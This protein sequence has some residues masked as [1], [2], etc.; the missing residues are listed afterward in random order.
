MTLVE[1]KAAPSKMTSLTS[2]HP[3]LGKTNKQTNQ[4]NKFLTSRRS[5]PA[6]SSFRRFGRLLLRSEAGPSLHSVRW[7]KTRPASG[8]PTGSDPP[9]PGSPSCLLRGLWITPYPGKLTKRIIARSTLILTRGPA[10]K[11]R[12]PFNAMICWVKLCDVMQT[13]PQQ[14]SSFLRN[15]PGDEISALLPVRVARLGEICHSLVKSKPING[16]EGWT[17]APLQIRHRFCV[18]RFVKCFCEP[19]SDKP[20]LN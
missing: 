9:F 19:P 1:G 14:P 6:P 5:S 2:R 3:H 10:L 17:E 11:Y 18:S 16:T 20:C 8:S 15:L 13:H 4:A 12:D 7:M